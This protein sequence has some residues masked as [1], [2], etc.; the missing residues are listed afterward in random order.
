LWRPENS[1]PRLTVRIVQKLISLWL[2]HDQ[3]G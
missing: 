3:I 2:Q 1:L